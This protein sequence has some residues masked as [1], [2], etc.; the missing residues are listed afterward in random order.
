MPEISSTAIIDKP[1]SIV[2]LI[3]GPSGIGKT[4]LCTKLLANYDHL[5]RAITTTSRLPRPTEVEG[6]DYYFVSAA[7]FEHKIAAGEFFE[8]A[9]VYNEWK[10]VYR[11]EIERLL[12]A[13]ED[14]LLNVDVQGAALY[15]KL[16]KEDP[17][18]KSRLVTVF[19]RPSSID[20]LRERLVKRGDVPANE[21]EKRLKVA[22]KEIAQASKFDFQLTSGSPADDLN[23]IEAV[24]CMAKIRYQ[25]LRR[26]ALN[27][28]V[29]GEADKD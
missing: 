15:R 21:L 6:V 1:S 17:I 26:D 3:T 25:K 8:H 13:G 12:R 7:T 16:A 22:E 23:Q 2:L 19:L 4:T 28:A 29:A 27:A 18:L 20:V 14:V 10:G 5:K 24:Y 9:L 11:S